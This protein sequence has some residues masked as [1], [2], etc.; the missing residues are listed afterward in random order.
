ALCWTTAAKM[1]WEYF[2]FS[3]VRSATNTT[4]KN[5]INNP[6][7]ISVIV[8]YFLVVL[9]VGIWAMVRTNRSTVGGFFLAGRSMV[10]WPIGASLFASNIGSGHFVGLAG[11][12]AAAGIAIGGFE[13]N[14]SRN[15]MSCINSTALVVVLILGWLF[16]PIYIKAGVVTM[17]EYLKKRF[18]GQ[19]IR[20][21]LSVLSLF[22]YIFTKISADMFSGAIFI[23]QALDLNIY[24][25]VV[26]LLL[27]TALYTVTGGLAAVIYTD[28]LQTI[29]MVVGS[30][31]LMG[32]AFDK[33]GGYE[34]FQDRYMTAIPSD[35]RNVSAK[36]YTP[37]ADSFHIFR[38]AV[39]GD[40]PW[41]GLTFGL[42]I[43]AAWYWCTDQVIVQRCLSAKN[44]SHVKGGCILC[45]YLKLLPMFLMVFPGMISRVL[46]PDEVACVV[47]EVCK[48]VCD[49]EVGCTNIAYPK[50]VV[51]LMPNGL[52]GL[53]LSVMLA[54]LMSSLT[55]IFNSASTLF[56]MDI[57]AKI[58]S[59]A[60]EKEL[61]IAGRLFILVLIGVSIAWIPIVQT[62]QSGQ[63]FDYI[64]SITSYLAPPIAAVFTLGI[65]C[66]RVNEQGAFYG[67]LI[68]L[69]IGLS[70]MISEFVYGT[71]S[72]V[73]PSNC[74][75]IIC[76][77]HYLY[78]GIILFVVSCILVLGI[79]LMTKPIDEK[80]LYR[81]CWSL[82]NSKE[83][84][85]DLEPEREIE[86]KDTGSMDMDGAKM[87]WNNFDFSLV[88]SASNTTNKNSVINNPADISVIV[89]YFVVVLAV[90][91]WAMMRTNRS[92]VGGFFLAGRSM[93]WW[94]IGAS[95]FAS[96]IGSG[97]FVG[98]AGTGAAAGI[99]TGEFEWNAL[100]V[101]L[102]LGW[103]FVPIYIKA[104]VVT[105]PE[106]LKKRFGGQ[107]IRIYLSVLS[108][109][110]YVFTK[111][112]ADMFSGAIFIKLAVD[113][114]IYVAVV[115]LL[116]IT[117]LYTVTGGLAA[118]IYTDTLQTIIMVVGSL[119]LM[120]FAFD[121]IGGYENLQDLYMTAIPSDVRNVSAECYTP[122]A[123]SFHIFR[124]AVTGDLPWPGLTIGL[125]IQAAWYWCSDQV[126]VQRCLSAKNM[127][128]V[129]AGCILCGYLKLLPMFIIVFPGMISR[130]LYP[131][132]LAHTCLGICVSV[133]EV[134]CVVPEVCKEVCDTEV[135]CTNIAYPK[136]VLDLMPNGLR[137]L[138]LS[139]MLA[140]LM[141]S[142]TSIFNSS[143]TL[144]T[145][146][147]YVKIRPR[148]SEKELMIAG[149][150]FI[151]VLIGVSIAWI[152]IVQTAQSGQL[153]DYTQS[154]TS[155]LAP[156]I[157]A[158]FA[159]AIFCKRVNEKGAFYGM[160]IGL[161]MGL[162]RMITE[163]VYGTGSCVQP[164]NCPTIICGVHYLYFGI[165]LCLVTCTSVLGISLM[166]KPIEDKHLHR[167]CWSLRNSKE[168]RI[169]LEADDINEKEDSSS[170]DEDDVKA[171]PRC[172]KKA[173]NWFCGF[174]QKKA[175]KLSEEEEA[176]LKKQLTDTSE[177]P[178]WRNVVN[179]NAIVLLTICVFFHGYF[180]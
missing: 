31:I 139:V 112:S 36:C 122:R 41:P 85:I 60:S 161:A 125:T 167:L 21:Y 163:F 128:H 119:I 133:D 50:L 172:W 174:D 83:E 65:F 18:G 93:V 96:N 26:L 94:P 118:V 177:R 92:T 145:M 29:I 98:L 111:I 14:A 63:L 134:A 5:A 153:Y 175:P 30:F 38:D 69:A 82:R 66:K 151:L 171:E 10:W 48:E 165:I 11:T 88:R 144:F 40:L 89:A 13:W 106:Y 86:E 51:D 17:P 8:I 143:S 152:P 75:T 45:G 9:A 15:L 80:H 2:G 64:Q 44:M 20:I 99:A 121:K 142:L 27:I 42:T 1:S 126:I 23:T 114:N 129:K 70:R 138:M 157:A 6:A 81:L 104:G 135:G 76:G 159:L 100:V 105:M 19:R 113:L 54:S 140:S 84:R 97:H 16:V 87:T 103:I 77:V 146:D 176:E 162:T 56:T 150:L 68:G 46:Y 166:T 43:Q 154:I 108:L 35:V 117:A 67:M 62:A 12:G 180:G 91:I 57:Y 160:L 132:L 61:M 28:T 7:D 101:V 158:V 107:R 164:S 136:L 109:F 168:E 58:R 55:S 147:I 123:D 124:D 79:S 149:R 71:G 120:G 148:A 39:S 173:Y 52:R 127:S 137:G 115:L 53:M 169:D 141:S 116:L 110:L 170:L 3:L 34:N 90:G 24:V 37:R 49:T 95:L 47:P 130:V 25:A 59:K 32:F 73:Q 33:V 4:S 156:P 178:L 78:F 74:P 179:A 155:Y 131:G 72:C 22:L 102:I